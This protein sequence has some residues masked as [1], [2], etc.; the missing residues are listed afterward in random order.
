MKRLT[1][2][3]SKHEAAHQLS[4]SVRKLELMIAAVEIPVKRI[5]G[6]VLPSRVTLA[7]FA[8]EPSLPKVRS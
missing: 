4:I 5:G 2:L 7:R 3:L 6:R 1:F 8:N